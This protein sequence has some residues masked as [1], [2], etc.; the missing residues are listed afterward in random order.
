[1]KRKVVQIAGFTKVVSIPSGWAKRLNIK[2]G[3]ELDIREEG[4]SL[5]ISPE[6]AEHREKAVVDLTKTDRFLRRF[7]DVYYRLG[8]DELE[9]NFS[10]DY[11]ISMVQDEVSKRLLGFEIVEQK[12]KYCKIRSISK[13]VEE[14]FDIILRRIFM[15]LLSMSKEG[16]EL[17]RQREYEKLNSLIT[18][19][20]VNNKF[21][22]FCQRSLNKHGHLDNKKT[23]IVYYAVT[24]LETIAD[25]YRDMFKKLVAGGRKPIDPKIL[26]LYKTTDAMLHDFYALFYDFKTERLLDFD[27][28]HKEI[29]EKEDAMFKAGRTGDEAYIVHQLY[30][31][32]GKLHHLSESVY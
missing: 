1:M 10:N 6:S 26:D 17:I 22:N 18:L 31:I 24:Q 23:T 20:E 5:I 13:G 15:M 32:A 16:L 11:A 12:D 25:A 30:S 29:L 9:V 4:N 14:E 7:I 19:E 21:T 28:K 27:R 8:Y 2:K 3:E